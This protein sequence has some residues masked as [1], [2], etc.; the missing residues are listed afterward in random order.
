[1]LQTLDLF[2]TQQDVAGQS[3]LTLFSIV[4]ADRRILLERKILL[5]FFFKMLQ[6]NGV[7]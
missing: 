6:R 7:N 4:L 3:G 1:M 2:W 5:R